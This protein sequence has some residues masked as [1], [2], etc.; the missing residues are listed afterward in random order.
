MVPM[1][2]PAQPVVLLEDQHTAD[3]NAFA[4]MHFKSRGEEI[5]Y[6]NK[7]SSGSKSKHL[8]KWEEVSG[9]GR[10]GRKESQLGHRRHK[11]EVTDHAARLRV[12]GSL[13]A[14]SADSRLLRSP[15][16]IGLTDLHGVNRF[17]LSFVLYFWT[18]KTHD[19][20]PLFPSR[21]NFLVD[22]E[23][24][25]GSREFLLLSQLSGSAW[26]SQAHG[27]H[28]WEHIRE[29]KNTRYCSYS[30]PRTSCPSERH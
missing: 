20:I 1:G 28:F 8:K 27:D 10:R 13:P 14:Y 9:E 22:K 11:E 25:L 21:Q 17:L 4:R 29:H 3:C 18:L 12:L 15:K 6:A 7:C 24:K 19:Q 30:E 2:S 16:Y 5:F 26:S 23:N